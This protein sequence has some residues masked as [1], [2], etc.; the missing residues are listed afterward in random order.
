MTGWLWG[1]GAPFGL[2]VKRPAPM[3]LH[4]IESERG[5]QRPGSGVRHDLGSVP[6]G[7]RTCLEHER[8]CYAK[9]LGDVRARFTP[10][11]IEEFL[12]RKDCCGVGH[13]GQFTR[14]SGASS[15][16]RASGSGAANL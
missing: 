9:F 12:P 11:Q 4:S 2:E 8:W 1:V 3:A 6:G 15:P 14:S 10:D 5:A 16:D 13:P 7:F